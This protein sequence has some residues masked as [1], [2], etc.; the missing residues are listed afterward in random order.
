[1]TRVDNTPHLL[2]AAVARHHAVL[3]RARTAIERLD[4]NAQPITFTAVARAA[5]ISRSWLYNQ[6]DLRDTI[7]RLRTRPSATTIP[8]AQR[9]TDESQRQRLDIVRAEISRLRTENAALRERLAR[10]LGEQRTLR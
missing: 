8:T 9:A 7:T 10:T 6:P 1:M 2:R 3:D 5:H 4:R